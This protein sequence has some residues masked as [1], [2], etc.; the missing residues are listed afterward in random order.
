MPLQQDCTGVPLCLWHALVMAS[1]DAADVTYKSPKCCGICTLISSGHM[2][3]YFGKCGA[4]CASC[5]DAINWFGNPWVELVAPDA[6]TCHM[7]LEAKFQHQW[8]IPKPC[9]FLD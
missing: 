1:A 8:G 5:N 2:E 9:G 4:L 3:E 7:H 6:S